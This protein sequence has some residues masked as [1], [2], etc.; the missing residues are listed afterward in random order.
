[1]NNINKQLI[2]IADSHLGIHQNDIYQMIEFLKSLNPK[3]EDLLFLGDIFHVWSGEK[4]YHTNDVTMFLNVLWEYRK[5]GGKVYLTV[6]NRDLFFSETK[7]FNPKLNLPFDQIAN[8][9]GKISIGNNK[10]LILTNHGDTINKKDKQYL[11]WR[12][13]VKSKLFRLSLQIFP[14]ECIKKLM[15]YL[16]NKLK[17]TNQ[18]FRLSFPNEEWKEFLIQTEKKFSTFSLLLI[19]HFHPEKPIIH[20]VNHLTGI[21]VP[22]WLNDQSYLRIDHKLNWK[23]DNFNSNSKK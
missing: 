1:M 7:M 2:V 5:Q 6:G 16:E 13:V 10:N 4:R 23:H 19:G 21:V 15:F 3:I 20:K 12:K 22:D 18:A 9:F 11:R 17:N 14:N 8:N